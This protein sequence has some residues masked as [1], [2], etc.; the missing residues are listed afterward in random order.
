MDR[1][2]FKCDTCLL[3]ST[4]KWNINRHIRTEHRE[5]AT[6]LNSKS[7][8]LS[9][10]SRPSFRL[11]KKWLMPT[12]YDSSFSE[13]DPEFDKIESEMTFYMDKETKRLI[14]IYEE[15]SNQISALEQFLPH[16][17]SKPQIS[18]FLLY[19]LLTE[20]PIYTLEEK[21]QHLRLQRAKQRVISYTSK[22]FKGDA[23]L[24]DTI[25]SVFIKETP[26]YKSKFRF[27]SI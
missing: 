13:N 26:Y 15:L 19:S 10:S 22:F 1:G 7:G 21:I 4:R 27:Q 24:T 9:K 23:F 5:N 14:S 11:V 6:A 12:L 17:I 18:A 8:K 2:V 16:E 20:N 25:V 3:E